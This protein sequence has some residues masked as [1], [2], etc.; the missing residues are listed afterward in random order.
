[1][2][3]LAGGYHPAIA[4]SSQQAQPQEGSWTF[5]T[6]H[7]FVLL[8][9][10]ED[11][12]TRLRDIADRV[13]ITE[14]AVQRIVTELIDAGYLSRTRAGRRNVYEVHGEVPL[15]HEMTRHQQ[16]GAMLAG[17]ISSLPDSGKRALRSKR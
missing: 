4:K 3:L 6:T 8:A 7:G 13:G 17:L 1:M 16:V 14:R 9:I 10:A 11:P 2:S 12:H 15:R 5:F